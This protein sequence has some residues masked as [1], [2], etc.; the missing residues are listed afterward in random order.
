MAA[1]KFPPGWTSDDEEQYQEARGESGGRIA[2][3]R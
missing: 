2:S 3:R 1:R